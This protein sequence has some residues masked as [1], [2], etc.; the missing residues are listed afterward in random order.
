MGFGRE[1]EMEIA[2]PCFLFFVLL[3]V[4]GCDVLER[5][6]DCRLTSLS[7]CPYG[8]YRRQGR[9]ACIKVKCTLRNAVFA[10]GSK[11]HHLRSHSP[12]G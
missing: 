9:R 2:R 5:A 10:E 6:T 12:R 11:S 4:D 1:V 8:V 7:S 3:F